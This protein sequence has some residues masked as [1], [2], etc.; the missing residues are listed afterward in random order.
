[1][2]AASRSSVRAAEEKEQEMLDSLVLVG[3]PEEDYKRRL[4]YRCRGRLGRL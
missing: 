2:R 1:M 3:F 4:G